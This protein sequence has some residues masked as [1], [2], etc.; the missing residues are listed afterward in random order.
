MR[1]RAIVVASVIA[2]IGFVPDA[3]SQAPSGPASTDIYL[4]PLSTRQGRLVVGAP[5]NVT[6]R[7]GY[8]NQPAFTRDGQ[9]LLYTVIGGDGQADI[10]RY[11][12]RSKTSRRL[13]ST[14]ESEYSP[15]VYGDGTR[16]SVV[17][18]EADSTQRLWS[19]RL[20]GSDPRL[21][22]EQF[23]PVGYHAWVDSA[24]VALFM[25]GSP[26]TL[27]LADTRTGRAD[28]VARDVGRS[29]VSLPNGGGF[30]FTQRMPDSS[31]ILTAVDVRQT[32]AGRHSMM[33]PVARMP[34]GADYV[35][36]LAPARAITGSG[37]KLLLLTHDRGPLKWEELADLSR[38]KIGRISRLALS[39]D[40]NSLAIVAE[41]L[42]VRP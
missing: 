12:L 6:R 23:K 9:A 17:R 28:T 16:F 3:A 22:F 40:R 30:S 38:Y 42:A 5:V 27:L 14:P 41:P 20:D 18:V 7:P 34:R 31:W 4:A 10:Y 1:A 24:T 37:S 11:D 21:V 36:W 2:A 13:T 8:D 33:L 35:V 25:L 32:R 29:L 26:N 19:F 15:T 39:P